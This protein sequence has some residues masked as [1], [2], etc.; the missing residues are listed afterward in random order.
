M[1]DYNFERLQGESKF[2]HLVRLSV[3]KLNKEHSMDWLEL[4]DMFGLDY[5]AE[6]LRKK[7]YGWK[8]FVENEEIE[9]LNSEEEVTYKET[10]E[11]LANGN[12][13]SDKLIKMSSEQSKDVDYLLDA[14]GFDKTDWELVNARN[15]IWHVYSKQDGVQELYSSKITVKPRVNGFDIDKLVEMVT[16]KREPIIVEKENTGNHSKLLEISLFDMHFG[17]SS[18]EYY[19]YHLNE[20]VSKIRSRKWDTILI[21]IGQDLLHND[22]FR[23]QT[24][25]GTNI[26]KVNMEVAFDEALMFYE[27]MIEEAI[28]E[29]K[30]VECIYVKGNHDESLSYGLFRTLMKS[31]REEEKKETI[32][33][34][35]SLKQRK[36]FTWEN[37]FI[38]LTHGDK[39]ANRLM[40][41]F[42]SE[43]GK[44]IASANIREIHSGHLHTEL[45]K[46]KFGIVQRTLS[47][48]N[49]T[50]DWHDDNGF[51]G[52]NKRFQLFEYSS[53]S[54][55][56][57][58]Y[59]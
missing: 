49:K 34:D 20:I 55:D 29:S 13:K 30:K 53:S 52:A 24:A 46:D 37:V 21:V 56:A 6:T 39:G 54:L 32:S 43:F 35:S 47:T 40:E 14:H 19:T 2:R 22:N 23:G 41:N 15:N 10:V 28:K 50:D 51:I 17:I 7:S 9:K 59:I 12:R 27:S 1:S 16:A 44:L 4:V 42:L 8:D 38:G 48:A 18:L 25:N 33:F 45:T 57:I 58:Y 31:F 36:A 11:I 26:D 5:S 3:A